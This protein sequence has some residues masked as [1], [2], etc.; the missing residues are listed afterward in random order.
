MDN[1]KIEISAVR[2]FLHLPLA[3]CQFFKSAPKRNFS[4]IA[5]RT[6]GLEKHA[7]DRFGV[8][9]VR[10]KSFQYRVFRC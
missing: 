10:A 5:V 1:P 6:M 9:E 2:I 7:V 3:G 4:S 8:I